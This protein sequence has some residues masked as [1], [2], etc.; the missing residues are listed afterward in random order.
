MQQHVGDG[1]MGCGEVGESICV[2]AEAVMGHGRCQFSHCFRYSLIG[3][4][5][6]V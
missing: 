4:K 3:D 1:M 6:E 5:S 2:I